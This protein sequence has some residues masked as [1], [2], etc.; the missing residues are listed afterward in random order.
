MINFSRYS[1]AVF[2]VVARCAMEEIEQGTIYNDIY[3]HTHSIVSDRKD[4]ND[5]HGKNTVQWNDQLFGGVEGGCE[6]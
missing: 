3:I 2:V 6:S 5:F 4:A 1:F